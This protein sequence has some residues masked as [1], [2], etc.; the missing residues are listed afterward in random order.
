MNDKIKL[1]LPESQVEPEA[2]A[3]LER[4]SKLPF[5]YKWISVMPDVHLGK[6]ACVGSVIPTVNAIIPAAVGVDIGCGMYA[7]KTKL[8][9]SAINQDQYKLIKKSIEKAIPMGVGE[10]NEELTESA[11]EYIYDLRPDEYLEDVFEYLKDNYRIDIDSWQLQLGSLGS[12]NHFI[13]LDKDEDDNLWV[14]LH[15]GSRGIGNQLASAYIKEAQK[16]CELH[17]VQLEDKDLAYLS[18]GTCA[19]NE[20]I[21]VLDWC[22]LYAKY[23]RKEMMNRV[24]E[25]ITI[26]LYGFKENIR[27]YE[28][29]CHHNFTQL[30]NHFGQ[31]I[32]VTRKGAIELR[33]GSTGIIPGSMGTGT[34]IVEGLGNKVS[35]ESAPHGAGRTMSRTK[36]KERFNMEQFHQAMKDIIFTDSKEL[37]DESPMAYKDINQIVEQ[38]KDLFKVKHYLKQMVNIKGL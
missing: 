34:L 36:A 33:A 7:V 6:G 30:E 21:K 24:L 22:Q 15:S 29:D 35:F 20:Y 4:M 14:V 28:T 27:L 25:Q 38:S 18:K 1:W 10:A 19:F 8:K 31:D 23:N 3:Q 12:G 13:E 17:H 9:A 5:I 11:K 32:Y 2:M 16:S 37:L 26:S